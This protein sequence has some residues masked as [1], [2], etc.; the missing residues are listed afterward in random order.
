MKIKQTM[1]AK[2]P[3][4]RSKEISVIRRVLNDWV[5]ALSSEPENPTGD[6]EIFLKATR[7]ATTLNPWFTRENIVLAL[8]GL[9][10][11]LR[12]D[13]VE[14]WLGDY[15]LPEEKAANPKRVALVAAGNVPMV[16]FHDILTALV[17][18]HSPVVK[19]SGQDSVLLPTLF[20]AVAERYSSELFPVTFVEENLRDFDAVIATGSNNTARYF[21]SYF[22]KYP[23][24]IRKNRSSV[25]ILDGDTSPEELHDLGRDFFTYFGLGCRNVAKIYIPEDFDL[26]RVFEAIYPYNEIINHHKYANN[27]DYYKA[28]WLLNEEK[29]LD[30]GFVLFRESTAL[31]SPV[32][33]VHYERYPD[34]SSLEA[35][36]NEHAEMIQCIVSRNHLPFG[37]S[38]QPE[39]WEYADGVDTLSFLLDLN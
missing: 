23:H 39:L 33:S 38:Q 28:T 15:D 31:G 29:L 16:G 18:G 25:A 7:Q 22:G 30:N 17:A 34:A 12:E 4:V 3:P 13:A 14:K 20:E 1:K 32:G 36:L 21:R 27:Y 24:I 2:T 35:H 8:E 10:H 19:L 6:E 11:M 5:T 37:K 26:D 9:A